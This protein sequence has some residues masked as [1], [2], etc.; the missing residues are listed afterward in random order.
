MNTP[1]E[2]LTELLSNICSGTYMT[3]E[4]T[5]DSFKEHMFRPGQGAHNIYSISKSITGCAVGM[6]VDEGKISDE[7]NI[8]DL[9]PELFPSDFH[10][11]WKNVKLKDVMTHKTGVPQDANIDIDV[12][13]FWADGK[14]DFLN[15]FLS[16]PIVYK[17]GKGPFI[18][19]DTNYYLVGRVVEKLTGMTCGAFLQER[20]FNPLEW[21]GNAWGVCPMNHT[22]CGTG[23]FVRARDL[24]ACGLMLSC[25]GVYKGKRLL[26]EEWITKARGKKGCY[27]Y[28]FTN[29]ADGRWFM[30]AG[31]LGQAVYVFPEKKIS[32]SVL[33]H[34]VPLETVNKEIVPLYLD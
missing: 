21:R 10:P 11:G 27:G 2:K 24:A 1:F 4:M 15:Y 23:L 14:S 7:D 8:Y 9:I 12:M 30:T 17:P 3:A 16:K 33:G 19:C 31:M 6:L 18:Y 13:D 28:G 20:L 22:L 5:E 29:S 26:S 32:F 25:G 34:D